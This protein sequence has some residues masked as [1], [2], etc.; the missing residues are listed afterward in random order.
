MFTYLVVV[1]AYIFLQEKKKQE[2]KKESIYPDFYGNI[3]KDEHKSL[4]VSN[5]NI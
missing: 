4:E 1:R 5:F 3:N 2:R